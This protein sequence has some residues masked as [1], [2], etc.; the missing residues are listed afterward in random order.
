M[1]KIRLYERKN[2]LIRNN[3]IAATDPVYF[4]IQKVP[5]FLNRGEQ[6]YFVPYFVDNCNQRESENVCA[7]NSMAYYFG[8]MIITQ[9]GS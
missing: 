9:F 1:L 7:G 6:H 4:F 2:R 8:H 5:A 3:E